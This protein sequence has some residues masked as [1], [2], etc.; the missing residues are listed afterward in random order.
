M[1]K[2]IPCGGFSYDD[3]E[4]AFD[5]GVIHTIGDYDEISDGNI[6]EIDGKKYLTPLGAYRVTKH[7]D[8]R[9]LIDNETL[10]FNQAGSYDFMYYSQ[11]F[12]ID[13][14]HTYTFVV[15]G[16]RFDN[17]IPHEREEYE[18][19]EYQIGANAYGNHVDFSEYPFSV[20][21]SS[22]RLPYSGNNTETHVI[23]LIDEGVTVTHPMDKSLF[24]DFG[25]KA[26][27]TDDSTTYK[28]IYGSH[29]NIKNALINGKFVTGYIR[30]TMESD[31]MYSFVNTVVYIHDE[32]RINIT[33]DG[34]ELFI[35]EDNTVVTELEP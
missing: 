10:E 25:I 34:N 16:T 11:E 22:I 17:L 31:I 1:I 6:T 5:N 19:Y 23:T 26:T 30:G 20:T 4:I 8:M 27:F 21:P 28:L 15:D 3:S 29:E 2:K 12:I 9:T 33:F 13:P 18:Q 24:F 35:L 7:E 14:S 32:N